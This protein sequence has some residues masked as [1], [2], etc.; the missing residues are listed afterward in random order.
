MNLHNIPAAITALTSALD[1]WQH[2]EPPP[3]SSRQVHR[4]ARPCVYT[5]TTGAEVIELAVWDAATSGCV[6]LSYNRG[7]A[8]EA[9]LVLSD[10]DQVLPFLRLVGAVSTAKHAEA[11]LSA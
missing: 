8:E 1:T 7:G 5:K 9:F 2:D 3:L 6:T 10:V 4:W 11:V